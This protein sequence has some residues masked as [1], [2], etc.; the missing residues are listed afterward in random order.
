MCDLPKPNQELEGTSLATTLANP[1]DAKDRNVFLPY[2]NPG[3]YAVINRDWRYIRYGED[4]EELYDLRA[5]PNEW[6][7]LASQ[8]GNKKVKRQLRETAPDV[9]A[10]PE[11]KLNVR[12]DLVIEGKTFRW[13]KGK[14]NFKPIPKY[15]P[16]STDFKTTPNTKVDKSKKK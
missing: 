9:F 16:Y 11:Q 5:D 3:E 6:N 13:E 10:A 14:G 1:M 4:G 12:K 2:M 8:T 7:N 15:R